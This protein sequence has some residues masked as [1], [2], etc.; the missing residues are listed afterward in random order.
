MALLQEWCRP[1]WIYLD[2]IIYDIS[3][4]IY[5][6]DDQGLKRGGLEG[7]K[8]SYLKIFLNVYYTMRAY[9]I[10]F[11]I[12]NWVFGLNQLLFLVINWGPNCSKKEAKEWIYSLGDQ[13]AKRFVSCSASSP[14]YR[15]IAFDLYPTACY[16]EQQYK[17]KQCDSKWQKMSWRGTFNRGMLK[18]F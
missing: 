18:V 5:H 16:S 15:L 4:W 1:T 9:K 2:I 10:V 8:A 14:F 6:E 17:W 11:M 7:Q 3:I 12:L 13:K